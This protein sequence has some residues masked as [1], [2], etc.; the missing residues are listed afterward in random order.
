[1]PATLDFVSLVSANLASSR[2]FYEEGLGFPSECFSSGP[3]HLKIDLEND[4]SLVLYERAGFEKQ[5]GDIVG[6]SF[7]G[8]LILSHT[9]PARSDVEATLARAVSAGGSIADSPVDQDWGGYAGYVK[10]PDGHLWE[11]VSE[12]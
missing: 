11:I 3:D 12:H 5:F 10:D 7:A 2:R 4:V 8:G 1:M 6:S 9:V